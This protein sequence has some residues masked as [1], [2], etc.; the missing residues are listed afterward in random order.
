MDR[1]ADPLLTAQLRKKNQQP[2]TKK[3]LRSNPL[4]Y[5]SG[6]SYNRIDSIEKAHTQRCNGPNYK[7]TGGTDSP[8]IP[9]WGINQKDS[10]RDGCRSVSNLSFYPHGTRQASIRSTDRVGQTIHR[11]SPDGT[12][13]RRCSRGWDLENVGTTLPQPSGSD[14]RRADRSAFRKRIAPLP[15]TWTRRRHAVRRVSSDEKPFL[16]LG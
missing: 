14:L 10:T 8:Q 15:N 16:V 3:G 1:S 2:R 6:C 11:Q 7:R 12:N 13:P 9:I 5:G 4:H